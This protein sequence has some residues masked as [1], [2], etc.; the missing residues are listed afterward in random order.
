MLAGLPFFMEML[1][2][3]FTIGCF[4]ADGVLRRCVG[5]YPGKESII[6]CPAAKRCYGNRRGLAAVVLTFGADILIDDFVTGHRGYIM[7][8]NL[9]IKEK[10]VSAAKLIQ[11]DHIGFFLCVSGC[12]G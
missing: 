3:W 8:D 1:Q 4:S 11:C 7:V 12:L 5:R 6:T 2:A 10:A 9:L